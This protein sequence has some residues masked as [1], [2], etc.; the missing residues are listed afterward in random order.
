LCDSMRDL[1]E[2]SL[3]RVPQKI[4]GQG[5]VIFVDRQSSYHTS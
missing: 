2:E 5:L 3:Y 1:I 4:L